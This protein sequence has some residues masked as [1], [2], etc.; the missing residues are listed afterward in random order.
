MGKN[1]LA[2][3]WIFFGGGIFFFWGT[4]DLKKWLERY[5]YQFWYVAQQ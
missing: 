4:A 5:F 3:L 1:S 2:F